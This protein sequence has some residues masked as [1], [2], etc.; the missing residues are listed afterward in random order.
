[1]NDNTEGFSLDQLIND[2]YKPLANSEKVTLNSL[3]EK[4][5]DE[6]DI[7][8][9]DAQRIINIEYRTLNG[10][11]SGSQKRVDFFILL[12]LAGFLKISKQDIATLYL[13]AMEQSFPDAGI[14]L[15]DKIEFIKTTFD[16]AT[17]KKVGFI[18]SITDFEEIEHNICELFELKDIF[19][20]K[21]PSVD[22][23][24][25]SGSVQPKNVQNR[26]IWL[27]QA[28]ETIKALKNPYEYNRNLLIKYFSK[29]RWHSTDVNHGL[30]N[31]IKDLYKLG[32][33]VVWQAS[34]PA[35]H[36]RGATIPVNGKPCI[37]LTNYRGFY[38]TIWFALL[39]E[40]YHVIFDWEEIKLGQYHFSEEESERQLSV[41][42]KEQEADN[43]ARE[44]LFSN[45]KLNH[46]QAYI[47]DDNYID[48]FA[49]SNHVHKS[50][51]YVFHAFSVS[52]NQDKFAWPR[53]QKYNPDITGLLKDLENSWESYKPISQFIKPLKLKIYN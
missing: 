35:I 50:F 37:V 42:E 52:K 27:M 6:L 17:L 20:Y 33:T 49:K 43:F 26:A 13:E 24:F 8:K 47:D 45:Q 23:A 14:L 18:K 12:K 9:T 41:R 38:P 1:M 4:R 31:V 21:S 46:I 7:T 53:A 5:L 30:V 22:V 34:L 40:L 39:H 15:S 44:Y 11:L 32:I 36:L 48:S 25:S 51:I 28:E 2:L 16:L 29:I 19:D 3:F 10:I